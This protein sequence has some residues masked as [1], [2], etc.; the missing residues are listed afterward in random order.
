MS[1]VFNFLVDM[2]RDSIAELEI[3]PLLLQSL[4]L[5]FASPKFKTQCLITLAACIEGCG[6]V[7]FILL[8]SCYSAV[9]KLAIETGHANTFL[10]V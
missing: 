7:S 8:Y 10:K 6:K 1:L 2:C 5:C 4:Q 3:G 9:T